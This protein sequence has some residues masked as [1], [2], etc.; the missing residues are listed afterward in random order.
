[1]CVLKL[2]DYA[3]SDLMMMMATKKNGPVVHTDNVFRHVE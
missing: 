2:M 3:R 1:M